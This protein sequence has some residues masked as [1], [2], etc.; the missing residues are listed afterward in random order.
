[1]KRGQAAGAAV[2]VAIIAI[3]I[4]GFVVMVQPEERAKLLDEDISSDDGKID[5]TKTLVQLLRES[6][7]RIDYLAQKDMEHPLPVVN[8]FTKTGSKV[9]AEKS[10]A[11]VKKTVFSEEQGNF[12]FT[13]KDLDHTDN[14]LLAFEVKDIS[15]RLILTLNGEQILNGEVDVGNPAPLTL[16]KGLLKEENNLVFSLSSP[17]LAFW[18]TNEIVLE[19]IKIVADVTDIEAQSSSQIFLVSDTEKRN[20]E[21]VIL[22][23]QPGCKYNEVGLLNIAVNGAELYDAVP[24]C[25]LAMVPIEFSPNLVQTGENRITFRTTKGTYLLSHVAVISKLKE[26]DFPTYYFDLSYEQYQEV[27]AGNRRVRLQ[28]SFVDVSDSKYGEVVFNGNKNHF[29]TRDLS[30]TMDLSADIVQ[31]ANSVKIK[32]QHTLDVRELKVDLVK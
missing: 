2:L 3:M 18:A 16:P 4:V 22:E 30:I 19:N 11:Y 28:M 27:K 5:N 21:K 7:G 6:P 23:F 15:G 32:P 25:D 12:K 24:D 26:V 29:D 20:M 9:I 17:G 13:I 31:G 1:M 10:T 8:I 14:F